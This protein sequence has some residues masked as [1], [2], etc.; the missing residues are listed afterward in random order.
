MINNPKTGMSARITEGGPI[1]PCDWVVLIAPCTTPPEGRW[2]VAMV[3]EPGM[4][5]PV[6]LRQLDLLSSGQPGED[7]VDLLDAFDRYASTS[8][9]PYAGSPFQAEVNQHLTH[10]GRRTARTTFHFTELSS[11]RMGTDKV[12][13]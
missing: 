2:F 6:P 7:T 1:V 3:G 12:T 9:A 8:D 5:A 4:C 11:K 10:Y 13:S